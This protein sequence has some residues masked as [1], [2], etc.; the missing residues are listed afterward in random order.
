MNGQTFLVRKPIVF[1]VRIFRKESERSM[2]AKTKSGPSTEV[3]VME[4]ETPKAAPILNIAWT[5]YAQLN[6]V[7]SRRSRAHK[8]L[9][10]WI[11]AMGILATLFA[12]LT[13][14]YFTDQTSLPGVIVKVLFVSAPVI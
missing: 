2:N 13:Q 5:R 10:I 8:R 7:S 9:R 3:S 14:A 6:A 1:S 12:I 4:T 11:A